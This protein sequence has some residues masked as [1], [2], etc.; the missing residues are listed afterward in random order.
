[1]QVFTCSARE[2]QSEAYERVVVLWGKEHHRSTI[3]AG[4]GEIFLHL[5][6]SVGC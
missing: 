1:M 3:A 5:F 4:L 2:H 6:F